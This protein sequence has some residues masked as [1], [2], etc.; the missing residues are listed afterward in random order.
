M[1]NIAYPTKEPNQRPPG[2]Q[3]NY[4]HPLAKGL[5]GAWLMNKQTY[6]YIPDSSGNNYTGTPLS[7]T[8]LPFVAAY[9]WKW[10]GLLFDG[11]LNRYVTFPDVFRFQNTT[12]Y[13][14]INNYN[15]SSAIFG[16]HDDNMYYGYRF[17][18]AGVL[19]A[20]ASASNGAMNIQIS[21]TTTLK[22]NCINHVA[23]TFTTTTISLY[24]NG[25]LEA[26]IAKPIAIAYAAGGMKPMIGAD[27]YRA[28]YQ[29]RFTGYYQTVYIYN[30]ALT[31]AE[32]STLYTNPYCMYDNSVSYDY[33][34][35]GKYIPKIMYI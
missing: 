19:Y 4:F 33:F 29:T 5:V 14:I 15:T 22:S 9:G 34:T 13:A 35:I 3:L 28:Q 10:Y 20:T 1:Y 11:G 30:R 32:I 21:G 12:I 23:L 6:Y 17:L 26:S 18:I 8:M 25:Q 24:L 2:S 31:S 16:Y 27:T 7:S